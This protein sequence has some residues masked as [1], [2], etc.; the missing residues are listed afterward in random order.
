MSNQPKVSVIMPS[1]NVAQYIRECM[2]SV[3]NQS[4]KDI[5]I[6]CV[7]AG[8]ADGTLEILQEYVNKDERIK[9]IHSDKKSYGH[10]INLGIEAANGEYIG[11]VETDDY[12]LSAMYERLYS[13][14][15][16]KNAQIVRSNICRF[17]GEG[18]ERAIEK[19]PATYNRIEY[20]RFYDKLINPN[21]DLLVF[22][23]LKNNV[24]GIFER[25]FLI[26][27]NIW[28][29][30]STGASF[31]D[32]GLWFLTMIYVERLLYID[33]YF[34][35]C[36]RDNP[37]SSVKDISRANIIC[38]EYDFIIDRLRENEVKYKQ[39]IPAY[40]VAKFGS[41]YFNYTR[42][43]ESLKYLFLKRM[44]AD[45]LGARENQELDMRLFPRYHEKLLKG[46]LENP[47]KWYL[48]DLLRRTKEQE[49]RKASIADIRTAIESGKMNR[50]NSD[51]VKITVIM[52]VYNLSEYLIES[53]DS[54]LS[55][56][57]QELE[58]ICV[59]DGSTDVSLPLLFTYFVDDFRVR[60]I[61]IENSG[62]GVARNIALNEARGEYVVFL[63]GDDWYPAYDCL[64][65]L[66][67]AA[68]ANHVN[69]CGGSLCSWVNGRLSTSYG[70]NLKG[71]LFYEDELIEYKD[72]QFDYS[73]QRFCFKTNFLRENDIYF[74]NYRR[75]QDPPFFVK[76]MISAGEFYA[77]KDY[78]Y[79]YRY[80]PK[81]LST[82]P[83]KMRDL[84]RGLREV[85]D[86]SSEHGLAE[87]HKL[88]ISRCEKDFAQVLNAIQSTNNGSLVKELFMLNTSIN[89][90][91]A[92]KGEDY[93]IAPLRA[94]VFGET[95]KEKKEN[96]I[97]SKQ[98]K[99]S[100]KQHEL[101]VVGITA[102]RSSWSYRI[103]RFITFIPRKIRGGI[104]CYKEHGF[105]Y[106][107][108]R[109][110][111]HLHLK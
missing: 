86:L 11:I 2:E 90:E 40:W 80:I 5:E 87:L 33:D 24:T 26:E 88:T 14:A 83:V 57:L 55:Q 17:F 100:R 6:I 34:Y 60:I 37:N 8:S 41:Y 50:K 65:K 49:T 36:R 105:K 91:L 96:I 3:V 69:I 82:D 9:L 89:C 74:P 84:M 44:V 18:A 54:V 70:E 32:N 1:L 71:N 7:D 67:K 75:Y 77:I 53:M 45:F 93:L 35:M 52:P 63:D 23:M 78:T 98:L 42:V 61:P 64:E 25:N 13:E 59:D 104:R 111:E 79:C 97:L 30:E 62:S 20:R 68:E 4:L 94:M 110:L 109:F 39:F 72:Y 12:V 46:I 43:K 95:A 15:I 10:Q 85:L 66:Y 31:Q 28:L 22:N 38:G 107:Y 76:A 47:R 21:D 81:T 48:E 58:I 27:N 99:D 29:N 19:I 108:Y 106:T 51:V 56:S 103:G 102:I 92:D 101:C 16:A 73:Y